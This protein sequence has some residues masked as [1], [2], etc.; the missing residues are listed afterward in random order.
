MMFLKRQW[1]NHSG[2]AFYSS[3]S[4]KIGVRTAVHEAPKRNAQRPAYTNFLTKMLR[5][6]FPT[7]ALQFPTR[8]R[9]NWHNFDGKN[10]PP[11]RAHTRRITSNLK[12]TKQSNPYF[13]FS[14]C[15]SR[16]QAPTMSPL[17]VNKCTTIV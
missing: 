13:P 6:Q 7:A 4:R 17:F 5:F 9:Q 15:K 14:S 3:R 8:F 16:Y 2:T 1:L 10:D 11:S 12:Q